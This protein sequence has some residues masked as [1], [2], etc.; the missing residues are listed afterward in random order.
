M[1]ST[2][3]AGPAES[4][5][6]APLTDNLP[7]FDRNAGS[8]AT[9]SLSIG[10]IS[11]QAG[12]T[13]LAGTGDPNDASDSY[14]G[15]GI[16]R[17]TDGG[18]TWTL[19]QNSD[20]GITNLHSFVGL[21]FAGFAWSTVDPSLVVAAVSQSAEGVVVNAS[22]KTSVMGL[23]V[24]ND[25]GATWQMATISDGAKTVQ[26]PMLAGGNLQG[27][28]A[29]AVVWNP[30]RRRFFAAVRYHGYYES[31]D[32]MSWTRLAHQP[33][34][35]MTL[36][37][38][39][40]LSGTAGNVSCPVFRGALAVQA[41]TGD[42]FA[43]TT[44]R[45]NIDQGLWQD[46]CGLSG[47]NCSSNTV[48]FA[49][50]IP[51]S[52]LEVGNGSAVIPQADY[53]L[54]L[55]AE[56][57]G[58]DTLLFVGTGDLFRCSLS[59]GCVLRNATNATNACAAP[60]K[61]APAQHA[62]A[63]LSSASFILLGTDGG[64]WRSTDN[65]N[66]QGPP[67]SVEDASHFQNLNSGLGSLAEII[68][69]AQDP[70]DPSILL[71]GLGAGGSVSLSSLSSDTMSAWQQ[72]SAGEGGTVAID[73]RN[74][75]LWYLSTAWGVSIQRCSAG[76]RCGASDFA[77][78]ATIG[79]VQTGADASLIDAPW[80][81]DPG[82][83]TNVLV[84]TCRVWRGP[85]D[86]GA[87][88]SSANQ[89]SPM[90]GGPQNSTCDP[91]TNPSVRSLAT[92]GP[93]VTLGA[94]QNSGSK[95]LYAGMAGRSDG[96]GAF[97]GHVFSTSSADLASSATKWVDLAASMVTN[98]VSNTG[99][100]NPGGFDI[101]AIAADPHDATGKTI[102]AA[103]MG[104]SG[105]G[106]SVPHLYGSTDGGAHWL[107]LSSNLPNAPANSVI[108]DPNRCQY[109]LCGPRHGSLCNDTG[110]KLRNGKLLECVRCGAAERA[111]DTALH[112]GAYAYG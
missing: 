9:A 67:C 102:Y 46:V 3:A 85:A 48:G 15:S 52:A 31:T 73:Q 92:A 112:S 24:S 110:C 51:S 64:L 33:G 101:S 78:P 80:M 34:A 2:N 39:P 61:V 54:S 63:A 70:Q 98:D 89:I 76:A 65:V 32:G 44:D 111:C 57:A 5:T 37:A 108:V 55:V 69:F 109:P 8:S 104:F 4:V 87:L 107:N 71:A 77:G 43:T 50:R 22:T 28:A 17:S 27:V 25:A 105:N 95:M 106:I 19:I 59:G 83:S 42:L 74:P 40:S 41:G 93:A 36:A 49:N 6:F 99:M 66:E 10:A 72:V 91:S 103:I 94:S 75:L 47:S 16:L 82:L 23:Y 45:N 26:T 13:V 100:F 79:A 86:S 12:G 7:A 60:A 11:V 97:P 18:L 62:I 53:D 14:Y 68:S 20:D 56:A 1:E 38:C 88:W 58:S 29:T 35:G 96:G 21:G 81:L 84:G 30:V 90:L